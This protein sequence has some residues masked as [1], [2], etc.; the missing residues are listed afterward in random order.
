MAEAAEEAGDGWVL[1]IGI[2]LGGPAAAE[3]T[4]VRGASASYDRRC[5]QLFTDC[6]AGP[7]VFS[8]DSGACS[9]CNW[10]S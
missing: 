7:L 3:A 6:F 5:G 8:D 2:Q 9:A 10:A 1:A 4:F